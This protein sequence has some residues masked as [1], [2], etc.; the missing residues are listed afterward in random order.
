MKLIHLIYV[1]KLLDA[2]ESVS[3]ETKDL[4]NLHLNEFEQRHVIPDAY[5]FMQFF[6]M[7]QVGIFGEFGGLYDT[8]AG[9]LSIVKRFNHPNPGVTFGRENR[10]GPLGQECY[11]R[12]IQN[13]RASYS[14]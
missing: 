14:S 12:R 9:F 10:L 3:Y 7:S 13:R 2:W 4:Y 8:A 1:T 11:S 6:D 5:I